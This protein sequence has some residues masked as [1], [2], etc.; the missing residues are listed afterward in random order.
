MYDC[1]RFAGAQCALVT[2]LIT[3]SE[4]A[5]RP[6][7]PDNGQM[8]PLVQT[9]EHECQ[10][11]HLICSFRSST[12][13]GVQITIQRLPGISKTAKIFAGWDPHDLEYSGCQDTWDTRCSKPLDGSMGQTAAQTCLSMTSW[14][15]MI[16][17]SVR[18]GEG[19]CAMS[20][21]NSPPRGCTTEEIC[22]DVHASSVEQFSSVL[23]PL[24]H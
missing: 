1:L 21:H 6:F 14:P 24:V 8:L 9:S 15:T 23:P 19:I 16:F 18:T 17:R 20:A 13:T 11:H 2:V 4:L 22:Q 3:A 7:F 5:S 10:P 12:S